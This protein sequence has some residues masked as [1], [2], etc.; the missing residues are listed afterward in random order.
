MS[1][2]F[3]NILTLLAPTQS[4]DNLFHS[5][6]IRCENEMNVLKGHVRLVNV[7]PMRIWSYT[8]GQTWCFP[9]IDVWRG[10]ASHF[11][12]SRRTTLTPTDRCFIIDVL[13]GQW[14][15]GHP[16]G[17]QLRRWTAHTSMC[18]LGHWFDRRPGLTTLETMDSTR[19]ERLLLGLKSPPAPQWPLYLVIGPTGAWSVTWS[20]RLRHID[21]SRQ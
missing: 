11:S 17:V 13:Y 6:S 21:V 20:V 16:P 12:R 3:L 15:S 10:C 1:I 18:W 7:V 19:C 5:F 4:A 9:T 8:T 14:R 2:L